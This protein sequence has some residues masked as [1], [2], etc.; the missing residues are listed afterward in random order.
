[1]RHAQDATIISRSV[2][3]FAFGS[4]AHSHEWHCHVERSET[5]LA[6]FC[7]WILKINPRFFSRECGI[8]MTFGELFLGITLETSF[9]CRVSAVWQGAAVDGTRDFGFNPRALPITWKDNG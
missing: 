3:Q 5:S 6:Y 4:N 1:M 2:K 9:T 7:A 8:R